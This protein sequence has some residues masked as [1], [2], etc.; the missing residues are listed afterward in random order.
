MIRT[1]NSKIIKKAELI[2][3]GMTI[4]G[5]TESKA[6]NISLRPMPF[7]GLNYFKTIQ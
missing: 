6:G 7:R 1:S 4:T 5:A 3:K 2:A